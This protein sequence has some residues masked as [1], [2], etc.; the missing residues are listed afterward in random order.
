MFTFQG[1]ARALK[2]EHVHYSGL[3]CST[4]VHYSGLKS[5]GSEKKVGKGSRQNG[6]VTS[7]KG[8]ALR[9][10]YGGPCSYVGA[11]QKLLDASRW[12][13]DSRTAIIDG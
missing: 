7:G 13:V 4:H 10:G 11:E 6:S 1:W 12:I 9:V 2:S 3:D 8:L 5:Y